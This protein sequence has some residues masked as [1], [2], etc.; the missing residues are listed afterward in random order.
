MQTMTTELLINNSNTN[1]VPPHLSH[2]PQQHQQH[3]QQ[4]VALAKSP[5]VT[6]IA[7]DDHQQT[8]NLTMNAARN[9]S[10]NDGTTTT[11]NNRLSSTN[12]SPSQSPGVLSSNTSTTG[13][14]T[15]TTMTTSPYPVT[16][17][18][19]ESSDKSS[20]PAP[21]SSSSSSTGGGG[22]GPR[23]LKKAWLQ[24]HTG[25]DFEDTTGVTGGGSCVKLPL[26][27]VTTNNAMT[28]A[29]VSAL[30]PPV[31]S[32]HTVGSMAINSINKTKQT[33]AGLNNKSSITSLHPKKSL[34]S[35]NHNFGGGLV[36]AA[37]KEATSNNGTAHS[38]SEVEEN[39]S[40]S[41]QVRKINRHFLVVVFFHLFLFSLRT[42]QMK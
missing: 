6:V 34:V 29:A 13:G 18:K 3:L 35:Q 33:A 26:T 27:I 5:L 25:E 9:D 32:L 14:G 28:P 21:K 37:G 16:P 10:S 24:R 23:H 36:A 42:F 30:N 19:S 12:S 41:D 31:H 22:G 11:L 2:Q 1:Q 7:A 20:S 8:I 17:A 38:D 4:P 39:S 40:S 15:I